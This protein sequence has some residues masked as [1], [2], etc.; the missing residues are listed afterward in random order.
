M[1]N[2]LRRIRRAH[3][4]SL[5]DIAELCDVHPTTV[6]RWERG[7]PCPDHLKVTIARHYGVPVW[8]VWIFESIVTDPV[9][10][11]AVLSAVAS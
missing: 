7:T 1:E 2:R 8:H 10:E 3:R 11:A 6:D 4:E 5:S 9:S